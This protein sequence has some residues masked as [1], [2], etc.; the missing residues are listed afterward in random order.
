MITRRVLSQV[1]YLRVGLIAANLSLAFALVFVWYANLFEARETGAF[2][3]SYGLRLVRPFGGEDRTPRLNTAFV[4]SALRSS[5]VS[6]TL[7]AVVVAAG[8][9]FAP[10]P[11]LHPPSVIHPNPLISWDARLNERTVRP[12][13]V[14]NLRPPVIGQFQ[15]FVTVFR[16]GRGPFSR[17][18]C[19]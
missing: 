10:S 13:S 2:E 14:E 1:S 17:P 15:R 6:T 5:S 9:S 11:P 3:T 18:Q 12:D 8:S 7:A 16:D 4:A 19:M